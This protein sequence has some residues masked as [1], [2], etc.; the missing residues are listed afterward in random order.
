MKSYKT[1]KLIGAIAL[2]IAVFVIGW[3]LSNPRQATYDCALAE[4][5]VDYPAEIKEACRNL[6]STKTV[7]V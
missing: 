4:I 7:E 6:Q 1:E 2:I 3:F 5:S